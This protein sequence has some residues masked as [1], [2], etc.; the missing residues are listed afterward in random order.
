MLLWSERKSLQVDTVNLN[1]IIRSD[2]L[3]T[4]KVLEQEVVTIGCAHGDV[5]YIEMEV[6]RISFQL[7]ESCSFRFFA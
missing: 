3:L 1:T 4:E 5:V 6:D 7:G 2:L